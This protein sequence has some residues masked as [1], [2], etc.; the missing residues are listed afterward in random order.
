MSDIPNRTPEELSAMPVYR[1]AWER[2]KAG[3]VGWIGAPAGTTLLV[4]LR[5]WSERGEDL[6]AWREV[7]SDHEKYLLVF[8]AIFAALI[9][10]HYLRARRDVFV[11]NR[12]R[13]QDAEAKLTIVDQGQTPENQRAK[14]KLHP[15]GSMELT[16]G[17]DET[18]TDLVGAFAAHGLAGNGEGPIS[19][20]KSE[21][22]GN[23][24]GP[25]E[26]AGASP[27]ADT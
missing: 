1:R 16:A 2:F 8:A 21:P 20:S 11:A 17:S 19:V 25:T 24:A 10:W 14:V 15:D 6:K 7:R 27:S 13:W 23:P 26:A 18:G 4:G 22:K 12:L 9:A 3:W 5:E